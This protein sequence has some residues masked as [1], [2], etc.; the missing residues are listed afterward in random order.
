MIRNNRKT[1]NLQVR[2]QI[3]TRKCVKLFKNWRE[4]RRKKNPF[5]LDFRTFF[6]EWYRCYD[7]G[8]VRK[9]GTG[10]VTVFLFYKRSLT[11]KGHLWKFPYLLL[12]LPLL[13]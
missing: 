2:I 6:S 4:G 8:T 7:A 5:A 9:K 13:T 1:K 12:P 10:V 11:L 3:C